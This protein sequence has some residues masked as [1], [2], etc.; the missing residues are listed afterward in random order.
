MFTSE[1]N[2]DKTLRKQQAGFRRNRSC[3]NHIY[4]LRVII[5]LI[6]ELQ[7]FLYFVFI[8]IEKAFDRLSHPYSFRQEKIVTKNC[9]P[10]KG[11]IY[12]I[13]CQGLY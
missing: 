5:E 7:Y 6:N 8:D 1:D 10:E 3:T 2:I 4:S 9:I 11:T 13:L 12:E